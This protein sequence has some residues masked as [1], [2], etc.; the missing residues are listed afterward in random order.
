MGGCDVRPTCDT[1][2]LAI[3]LCVTALVLVQLAP[4]QVNGWQNAPPTSTLL[5]RHKVKAAD[6]TVT[7]RTVQAPFHPTFLQEQQIACFNYSI[8]H[9]H[10]L[11][12][13]TMPTFINR[14]M[15]NYVFMTLY[16]FIHSIAT[17]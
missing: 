10:S 16:T 6:T 4:Y 14:I 15:Y 17:H 7:P 9:I 3:F 8:L 11:V 1:Q 12:F 5:A 13:L 2:Q